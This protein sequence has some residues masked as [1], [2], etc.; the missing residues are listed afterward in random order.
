MTD[1]GAFE[2]NCQFRRCLT[3]G[4]LG[5]FRW[6]LGKGFRL[7]T[8][9]GKFSTLEEELWVNHEAKKLRPIWGRAPDIRHL[10][11]RE[12]ELVVRDSVRLRF[13]PFHS[14]CQAISDG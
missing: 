2:Q 6:R 12:G 9:L 11:F 5:G 8:I 7:E 1:D 14:Q 13:V 3:L 10:S 4:S